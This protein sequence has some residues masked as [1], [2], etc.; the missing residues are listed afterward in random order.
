MAL[1]IVRLWAIVAVTFTAL[2]GWLLHRLAGFRG[3]GRDRLQS[4]RDRTSHVHACP[5]VEPAADGAAGHARH[6]AAE[7][8]S[9]SWWPARRGGSPA[10]RVCHIRRGWVMSNGV[11]RCIS[12]RLSQIT[13]SPTVPLVVVAA[14]G[15]AARR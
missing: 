5:L 6:W 10:M 1:D 11:A 15:L 2:M 8:L 7:P 12:R 9:R 3:D 4:R 14:G 13:A